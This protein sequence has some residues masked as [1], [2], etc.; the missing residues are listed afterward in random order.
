MKRTAFPAIMSVAVSFAVLGG[1]ALAAQNRST[2]KVPNGLAFS[3]FKGYENWQYVAV[4]QTETSVKIIAANP[5]MMKAFRQGVP[6]NHQPFPEGSK[7]V[8]IEWIL[9]KNTDSPYFVNVPDTLKT[10][11]FIEKDSKHSRIPMA[12]PTPFFSMTPPLTR[13]RRTAAPR[14]M[15]PAPHAVTRVIRRLRQ[16]TTSS[17]HTPSDKRGNRPLRHTRIRDRTI[18]ASQRSPDYAGAPSGLRFPQHRGEA[19]HESLR[20][21][22]RNPAPRGRG[23]DHRLSG[24]PHPRA[25]RGR[26]HPPDHR[27]PGAH[28]PAH[29][30]RDVARHL[31]RASSACS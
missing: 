4:S 3:E 15:G 8:K 30:G 12:G 5:V 9:K 23:D 25:R 28:R 17:R 24:Q 20:R 18:R 14:K 27:A 16:Q 7:I 29:G 31:R 22:R 11:A 26:R 13:S 21:H 10:L 19:P 1:I 6:G 2:L